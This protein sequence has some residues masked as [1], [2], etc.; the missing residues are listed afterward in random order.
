MRSA[1]P[2]ARPSASVRTS[3]RSAGHSIRSS[4]RVASTGPRRSGTWRSTRSAS[5]RG[6]AR[7]RWCGTCGTTQEAPSAAMTTALSSA[8]STTPVAARRSARRCRCAEVLRRI[9]LIAALAAIVGCGD[10]NTGVGIEV[11]DAHVVRLIESGDHEGAK[12]QRL[13]VQ[14]DGS[15]YRGE[16]VELEWD[17]RRALNENGFLAAGDRV[18]LTLSRT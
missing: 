7:S 16:V 5:A 10:P 13:A 17:G 3:E 1:S 18:L 4:R 9:V 11:I 8:S 6:P 15:L 2:S 14:L 12:Y